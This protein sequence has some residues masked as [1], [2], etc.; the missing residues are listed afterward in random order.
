VNISSAAPNVLLNT[1]TGGSASGNPLPANPTGPNVRAELASSLLTGI[2]DPRIFNETS[3]TPDFGPQKTHEWSFGLQREVTSGAVLEA[4]YVGN[5]ATRLFQSINGNPR[6][7]GLA[8]LYPNLVPSG[9]TPCPA[10]NAA[11][12]AAVGR[13]DCNLGI[14]RRRTNTGFSDY[15]GLQL[16]FRSSRLWHQLALKTG[17]TFSKTTDNASE[18]FGTG[19][20]GGTSAFAQSQVDFRK[21]E[22]G[23]SGLDFRHNWTVSFYEEIPAFR[24]QHSVI[25]HILGG[26]AASGTYF[27]ASGQPYTPIQGALNCFSG[28]G[29]CSGGG[30]FNPYDGPFN[31]AFV[32]ADGALRPFLGSNSAPVSSVGIFAGDACSIFAFTGAE[33]ICN[34]AI[35]NSLISLNGVNQNADTAA[36]LAA[37]VPAVVTSKDVRFIANTATANTTFGTPFGNAGRNTLRDARTNIGNFSFYKTVKVTEQFKVVWHMT[38]LN[39]FN[40]PNFFSIDPLIDDAGF[41]TE[42]NGF[43]IPSLTSGGIQTA[44]GIPGRS[45]RFGITLRW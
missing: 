44:T 11:V 8:A 12:P 41:A 33:P 34:P 13:E 16:E 5:H 29:S 10:A 23:L 19:A 31:N 28:G 24:S 25:G 26:W 39:V 4:R 42:G 43:G 1:L 15:N 27:M 38:M 22:H 37:Y 35:A 6:I 7:D 30:T 14:V 21:G 3:I 20:A 9:A 32:G 18:I 17:Y 36:H 45:I 40:H 2:F